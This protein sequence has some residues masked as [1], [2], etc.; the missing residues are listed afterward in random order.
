MMSTRTTTAAAVTSWTVPAAG[1]VLSKATTLSARRD[2]S[3]AP[4]TTIQQPKQQQQK[5]EQPDQYHETAFNVTLPV[6]LTI[7]APELFPSLSK[8]RRLIRQKRILVTIPS[9][10]S[11]Q[12][13]M[14]NITANT[15]INQASVVVIGT[16]ATRI[17]P[18]HVISIPFLSNNNTL[19]TNM[20]NNT[21]TVQQQQ[22]PI[23]KGTGYPNLSYTKVA[24]LLP[25]VVYQDDDIAI[26]YKLAGMICHSIGKGGYD[27]NSILK[28]APLV[29]TPPTT[30]RGHRHDDDV[31]P[32]PTLVHRLD[33]RTSGLLIMSKTKTASVSLSHRFAS[34]QVLKTYHAIVHG[35]PRNE[36]GILE[37]NILQVIPASDV[38][39]RFGNGEG[40]MDVDDDGDNH[41]GDDDHTGKLATTHYKVLESMPTSKGTFLSWI[42]FQPRTGRR[43]QLRQ[44]AAYELLCPIVGDVLYAEN[45]NPSS[46]SS[47]SPYMFLCSTRIAFHHPR[48]KEW[49]DFSIPTPKRF[50]AF[51]EREKGRYENHQRWLLSNDDNI[52][53]NCNTL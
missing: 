6:A 46:S 10:N 15:T 41:D 3:I 16:S 52:N 33:T 8:A 12:Q 38:N 45:T 24:G 51:W 22:Q 11:Q 31:L 17:Y 36:K 42:E 50:S 25:D 18:G 39:S 9:T 47:S 2:R 5:Q 19:S 23:A 13:G 26:L 14:E 1:L 32:L 40:G 21:S 49:M 44:H 53:N 4:M 37:S 27:S 48:T 7:L 28:M 43:H 35:R 20:T 34:Q 30:A 29:L